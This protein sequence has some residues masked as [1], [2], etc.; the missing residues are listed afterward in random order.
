MIYSVLLTRLLVF[1][2]KSQRLKQLSILSSILTWM[3]L[4]PVNIAVLAYDTDSV[5]LVAEQKS[6]FK[7]EK[8]PPF[9]FAQEC[10][11][12]K[13]REYIKDLDRPIGLSVYRISFRNLIQCDFRSVRIL[14]TALES[15]NRNV[16]IGASVVLGRIGSNATD[17][18]PVLIQRLNDPSGSV[19]VSV[20]NSLGEILQIRKM[21]IQPITK[22]GISALIKALDDPNEDVRIIAADALG[23]VGASVRT[24]LFPLIDAHYKRTPDVE[25]KELALFDELAS[26]ISES[27]AEKIGK[28]FTKDQEKMTV[29][30]LGYFEA[31][32]QV[33]G[34]EDSAY[35]SLPMFFSSSD[36]L[37]S[38]GNRLVTAIGNMISKR[39]PPSI[40]RLSLQPKSRRCR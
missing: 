26:P 8:L 19:R 3:A 31:L 23:R 39:L 15:Q 17:A 7:D 21:P 29:E 14:K 6:G 12:A 2:Q 35:K 28:D 16:R 30:S 11:D 10:T 37:Q 32:V 1:D 22:T 18:V 34:S 38:G 25:S 20:A 40:C 13:M 27:L 4:S 5:K 9:N 36:W 33:L 24:T